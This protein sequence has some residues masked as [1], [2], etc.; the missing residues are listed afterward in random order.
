MHRV[1]KLLVTGAAAIAVAGAGV[2]VATPAEAAS[3]VQIYRVYYNSPGSDT[4]SNKSLNGEWVQLFNTSRLSK[5]LKG[6]KL[7]DKTG[8]TYTFGSYR[9]AGRKSVYIHTGKGKNTAT[10]RYWGKSWYV[11]NNTGDTA[12]LL[13]ANGKVADKCSWGKKGSST[14]C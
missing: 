10:H 1:R 3:P 4:G 8:Y 12:Y 6:V 7:R 9:I 5:S 14:Y 11:W 2:L 13:Y